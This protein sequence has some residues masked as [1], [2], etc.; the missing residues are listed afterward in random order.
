MYFKTK[1]VL[2]FVHAKKKYRWE[3]SNF[4]DCYSLEDYW[5]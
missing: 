5:S 3:K 4:A 2:T 1:I